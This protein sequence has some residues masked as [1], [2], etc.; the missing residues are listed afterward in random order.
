[1]GQ[2]TNVD[3]LAQSEALDSAGITRHGVANERAG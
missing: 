2:Q 3:R 1:M